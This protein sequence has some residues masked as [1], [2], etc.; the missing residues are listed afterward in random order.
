MVRVPLS[1][2]HL[3]V[4]IL[5]L[6]A[7]GLIA[8]PGLQR[9]EEL[10]RQL[11]DAQANAAALRSELGATSTAVSAL[12]G[13]LAAVEQ[14]VNDTPDPAKIAASV[15]ASV[16]TV[17]AHDDIGSGFVFGDESAVV[18]NFHVV[19][20]LWRSGAREVRLL[21]GGDM[22]TGVIDQV[23]EQY[24]LAVIRVSGGFTKLPRAAAAPAVGDAVIVVGSPLG[25]D[26][27]VASGI[28]SALR[29]DGRQRLVQF[30]APVSPGSSGGPVV[31]A[32]GEVIGVTEMKAFEH[33]AE[34]LSFAIPIDLVCAT[35]LAC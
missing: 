22:L 13:R 6:Q 33:G 7:I 20:P 29:T 25:L 8:L 12:G 28:V 17:D 32:R 18:T 31:N 1:R 23:N 19:E 30:S 5:A 34:G 10:A 26:G 27:T 9:Q 4:A 15:R 11:D 2:A 21:R 24:D 35:V 16:F 14:R 3:A